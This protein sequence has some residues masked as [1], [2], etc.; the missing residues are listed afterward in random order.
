MSF[1]ESDLEEA[2][3]AWLGFGTESWVAFWHLLP[4]TGDYLRSGVLPWDKMASI[5]AAARLLGEKSEGMTEDQFASRAVVAVENLR[6]DI[7]I[8]ARLRELGVFPE[9]LRPFAEKAFAIRRILRVNP[10][11]VTLDDLEAILR[12]AC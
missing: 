1:A 4:V 8:P 7:G 6:S 3:I 2:L 12:A 9:Q 11:P 10:R 5:F